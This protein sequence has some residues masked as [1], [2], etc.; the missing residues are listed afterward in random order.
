MWSCHCRIVASIWGANRS[1][2]PH[3]V[4]TKFQRGPICFCSFGCG[5]HTVFRIHV[6]R[7]TISDR[8]RSHTVVV[9]SF[10]VYILLH[11]AVVF[12]HF[13]PFIV[14]RLPLLQAKVRAHKSVHDSI[15]EQ[16][17]LVCRFG[18]ADVF[19]NWCIL[20]WLWIVQAV[21]VV[22][23]RQFQVLGRTKM[24]RNP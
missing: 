3:D 12:V 14:L 19:C 20:V 11:V 21:C 15:F 5:Q 22:E 4:G 9:S 17:S 24:I 16:Q 10:V 8:R 2:W 18:F 7:G 6:L 23:I 1:A 13:R